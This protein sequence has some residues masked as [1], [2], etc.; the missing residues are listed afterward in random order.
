[1]GV[2]AKARATEEDRM[3][4]STFMPGAYDK[5]IIDDEKAM[6]TPTQVPR[7][8]RGGKQQIKRL[9]TLES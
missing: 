9:Y 3:N 1:M 2:E 4:T 7:D 8:I 6:L 5:K